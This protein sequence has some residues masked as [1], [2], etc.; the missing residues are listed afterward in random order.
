MEIYLSHDGD[1]AITD[2]MK[3]GGRIVHV[4]ADSVWHIENSMVYTIIENPAKQR[5]E[6]VFRGSS[7]RFD[8]KQNI[9]TIKKKVKNPVKEMK[10]TL[11]NIRIHRGF[12]EVLLETDDRR[13]MNDCTNDDYLPIMNEIIDQIIPLMK[14][15][16]RLWITGHSLGGALAT[17]FSFYAATNTK[18][19]EFNGGPVTAYTFCSPKVGN[20][21][22][23][24][25]YQYLE[26]R[27]KLRHARFHVQGDKGE[28][29]L[30]RW[31]FAWMSVILLKHVI[32]LKT[33]HQ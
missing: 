12:S 1:K 5:I 33:T 30:S 3:K 18:I 11:P 15:G 14:N 26:E 21:Q 22:F 24:E 6:V 25:A 10:E 2:N 16:Y 17:L 7:S 29:L 20:K 13:K 23:R 4:V 32:L 8:W 31:C 19:L 28:I 9:K 27:G